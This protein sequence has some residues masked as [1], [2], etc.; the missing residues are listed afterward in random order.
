MDAARF[1]T[2]ARSLTGA[3]SRR[4]AL[5]A[6]LGG[7]C[8][9]LGLAHTDDVGAGGKCK[10]A[11]GECQ[12]C[13]KGSCK[14][15]AHG[16]QCKKGRCQARDNGTACTGGSCQS[17]ICVATPPCGAGCAA[18]ETCCGGACIN[19]SGN[20]N[21]CGACGVVCPVAHCD[22]PATP[23]PTCIDFYGWRCACSSVPPS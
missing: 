14:K 12:T 3:R 8:G 1:D 5:I 6:A 10:P 2:V 19:T 17:G 4:Q 11:C 18:D 13:K 15:T 21:H 7:A 9:L 20:V 23:Y 22:E 16:K